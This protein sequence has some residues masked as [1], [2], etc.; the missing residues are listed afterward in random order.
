MTELK[1]NAMICQMSPSAVTGH[2]QLDGGDVNMILNAFLRV[3]DVMELYTAMIFLMSRLAT[4]I[5]N[6]KAGII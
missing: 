4:T 2:A 3:T 5:T 6:F 1:E